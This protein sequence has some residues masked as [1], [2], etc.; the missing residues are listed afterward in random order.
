MATCSRLVR[1]Q[2]GWNESNDNFS[3]YLDIRVVWIDVGRAGRAPPTPTP[4][5]HSR[6]T[7]QAGPW[8][9]RTPN[10]PGSRSTQPMRPTP[11]SIPI[12]T[13]IGIVQV[14]DASTNPT[15]TSRSS[16]PSRTAIIFAK[17]CSSQRID[18]RW[19]AGHGRLAIPCSHARSR[20]ANEL[21]LN[22]LKLDKFGGPDNQYG[23]IVDDK[24]TNFLIVDPSDDVVLMA[25]NRTDAWEIYYQGSP[26][27]LLFATWVNTN[28]AGTC[29]TL[30]MT[31]SPRK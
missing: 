12:K 15:P 22:Y 29:L 20:P 23:Y 10:S 9:D 31:I 3:S 2:T 21:V 8:L 11:T 19:Y 28:M 7:D 24:D 5:C 16:T 13:E 6:K 17:R 1:I 26:T 14:P 25:G 30:M 4:A 18:V 27:R